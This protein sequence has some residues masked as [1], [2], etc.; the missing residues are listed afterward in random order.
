MISSGQQ[1]FGRSDLCYLE[2]KTLK[3]PVK[4]PPAF[5]SLAVATEKAVY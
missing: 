5:S 1:V 4:N 2:A 3:E